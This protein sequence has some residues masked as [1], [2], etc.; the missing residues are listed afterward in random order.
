MKTLINLNRSGYILLV[1]CFCLP[2]FLVRCEGPNAAEMA[3]KRKDDSLH[4]AD[5]L[6]KVQAR[7]DKRVMNSI[8]VT[9]STGG[10]T[11]PMAKED[12]TLYTKVS[13]ARDS[14]SQSGE[15]DETPLWKRMLWQITSPGGNTISG[16]G[17]VC[18][19]SIVPTLSFLSVLLMI[20]FSWRKNGY[21]GWKM[22]IAS[23]TGITGLVIFY[24]VAGPEVMYGV[25]VTIGVW[26]LNLMLT[27]WIKRRVLPGQD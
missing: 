14:L 17:L 1:F 24:F 5:S 13:S 15:M 23:L 18:G 6:K 10:R 11:A 20:I 21:S 25:P 2:F 8:E 3:Y 16:I 27:L 4:I 22:E 12:S 7:F 9:D 19:A 26:M